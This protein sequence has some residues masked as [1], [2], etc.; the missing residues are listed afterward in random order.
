MTVQN[1]D[2]HAC[3]HVCV[4]FAQVQT[5]ARFYFVLQ[6]TEYLSFVLSQ[7]FIIEMLNHHGVRF[8]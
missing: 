1:K 6:K 3:A 4:D 2:V 8:G 7:D 5:H